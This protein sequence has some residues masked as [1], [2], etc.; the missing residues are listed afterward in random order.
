MHPKFTT[1]LTVENITVNIPSA[2]GS[3]GTVKP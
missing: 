3:F 2:F 1:K